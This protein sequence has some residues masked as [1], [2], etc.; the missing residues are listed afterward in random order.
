MSRRAINSLGWAYCIGVV[1]FLL[2]PIVIMVPVSFGSSELLQFPPESLSLRWYRQVLGDGR[3]LAS[4]DLSLKIGLTAA[5]AATAAGLM[6][7]CAHLRHGRISALLRTYMLMPLVA[8]HIVLATGLFSILLSVG[9]FGSWVVLAAAHACLALPLTVVMFINAVD[10]LDPLLW[11]ASSSLGARWLTTIGHVVLPNIIGTVV[12]GFLLAFVTS[13]DEV[14][15]AVF[16]GPSAPPTLP[17][18]MFSYLQ[19]LIDPSVTAIATLL[20]ALTAIVGMAALWL[21]RIRR[22][23]ASSVEAR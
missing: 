19:E 7:S 18:R 9:Q 6:L 1:A 8:P 5:L 12:L 11:T 16:V 22:A 13:W 4:A 14:T 20:L 23:T 21:P 3:W 17:S 15:L 10:N 2:T